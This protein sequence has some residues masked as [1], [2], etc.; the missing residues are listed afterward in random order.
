M[1][2][3]YC[4]VEQ[5]TV[6]PWQTRKYDC[7]KRN[8]VLEG[9]QDRKGG[10]GEVHSVYKR[11]RNGRTLELDFGQLCTVRVEVLKSSI[12]AGAMRYCTCGQ[13]LIARNIVSLCQ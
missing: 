3:N 2:D 7:S 12:I 8:R 9:D 4:T 13:E 6:N 1:S 11:R 10:R 5:V